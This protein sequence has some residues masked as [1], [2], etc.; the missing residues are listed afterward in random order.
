MADVK[1]R[2]VAYAHRYAS[3]A[4]LLRQ[5]HE[6]ARSGRYKSHVDIIAVLETSRISQRARAWLERRDV[7]EQLDVLCREALRRNRIDSAGEQKPKLSPDRRSELCR[8]ASRR[9]W[10]S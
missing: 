9:R 5:A 4:F 1:D 8:E 10:S 2:R 3:S 6:L 7:R